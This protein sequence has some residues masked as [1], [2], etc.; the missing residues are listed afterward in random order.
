MTGTLENC[1][2][3]NTI[4]SDKA[5]VAELLHNVELEMA[6]CQIDIADLKLELQRKEHEWKRL[7][8]TAGL[9]RAVLSPSPINNIPSEILITIFTF[10]CEQNVFSV[11]TLPAVLRLSMVSRRWRDII[12][13]T[14]QLWSS[15]EIDFRP[16]VKGFR[17]L[18][19]L[20]E[21]F[22]KQ[23]GCCPLRFSLSNYDGSLSE[24]EDA[25]TTLR[26]LAGQSER[27]EHMSL[28][29]RPP[30]FPSSIF[31]TIRG[32]L[33]LLRSLSV[34]NSMQ[35][36]EE[37]TWEEPFDYFADCPALRTLHISPE[38][39]DLDVDVNEQE[40]FLPWIQINTLRLDTAYNIFAFPLLSQC[41]AVERV[42]LDSVGGLN[43]FNR[44]YSSHLN[45]NT[46]KILDIIEA[47]G[48]SD[49]DGVFQH[50]TMSGLTSLRIC[51]SR[52]GSPSAWRVW[53]GTCL[54]AFL[55]R[56]SCIITS[57]HLT[58][59]PITVVQTLSLL[60]AVP[61]ITSLF[62]E[63]LGRSDDNRIVTTSFLD[64]L[65]A[66]PDAPSTLP[67]PLVP[68]LV[69]LELRVNELLDSNALSKTLLSR[70]LPG[71]HRSAKLSV[72][73]LRFVAIVV[74][75]RSAQ[76]RNVDNLVCLHSLRDAGMPLSITYL[77]VQ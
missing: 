55:Q 74:K 40:V 31:G 65:T 14:S 24:G 35:G 5:T 70:W 11:S 33:P 69:D 64:R 66:P 3:S 53:D 17:I 72:E 56:S 46:V 34:V 71:T 23:S 4:T 7:D 58:N 45:T 49:L 67:T 73:C 41:T 10:S 37:M 18:N 57:L 75:L 77:S 44:D 43:E 62:I 12:F 2:V 60:G 47:E 15:I 29:I 42:E 38:L 20:S 59:L 6:K 13:S 26:L 48:Q 8:R 28:K 51:G 50:T 52:D 1:E 63:E 22:I 36:K 19:Q 30:H 54:E 32:R 9:Y 27:W 76:A 61:T 21:L 39:F 68:H 16:W 25:C